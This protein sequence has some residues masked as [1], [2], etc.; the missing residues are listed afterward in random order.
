MFSI[1][2]VRTSAGLRTL[3][4][5]LNRMVLLRHAWT[6]RSQSVLFLEPVDINLSIVAASDQTQEKKVW[7]NVSFMSGE[8]SPNRFLL[9]GYF[10]DQRVLYVCIISR[11]RCGVTCIGTLGGGWNMPS[12]YSFEFLI[13]HSLGVLFRHEFRFEFLYTAKEPRTGHIRTSRL[14]TN[15]RFWYIALLSVSSTGLSFMNSEIEQFVFHFTLVD[16][17]LEVLHS[18]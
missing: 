16:D 13:R 4:M 3:Q 6:E 12:S 11:S 17:H 7:D 5:D 9:D 8:N 10:P 15:C 14:V 2:M 1:N 18:D